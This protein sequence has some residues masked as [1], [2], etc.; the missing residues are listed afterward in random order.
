MTHKAHKKK[1]THLLQRWLQRR[2]SALAPM[3]VRNPQK[4]RCRLAAP[5]GASWALV[6]VESSVM[7]K[8]EQLWLSCA[9]RGLGL[10]CCCSPSLPAAPLQNTVLL[11]AGA[12]GA[13]CT[14]AWTKTSHGREEE[15]QA[16]STLMES[17]L[18][19]PPN[20]KWFS[21]SGKA[22]EIWVTRLEKQER[23]YSEKLRKLPNKLLVFPVKGVLEAVLW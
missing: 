17:G 2:T 19:T 1:K 4:K 14:F 10:W 21:R 5:P 16:A 3:A 6:P 7:W 20:T 22:C 12:R 23:N 11:S 9:T 18:P 15:G 8:A 13:P